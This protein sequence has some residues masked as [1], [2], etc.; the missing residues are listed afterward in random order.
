MKPVLK[1]CAKGWLLTFMYIP[2]PRSFA[3]FG[4]STEE[5]LRMQALRIKHVPCSTREE[6]LQLLAGYYRT[7]QV[8]L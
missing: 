8:K 1:S 7:K 5:R 3:L 6:G 4:M 2:K